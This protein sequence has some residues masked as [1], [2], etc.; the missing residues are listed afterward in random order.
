MPEGSINTA[1]A[2]YKEVI[3]MDDRTKR[4][5]KGTLYV[6]QRQQEQSEQVEEVEEIEE[7]EESHGLLYYLRMVGISIIVLFGILVTLF[8]GFIFLG[9][10]GI[11]IFLVALF[12]GFLFLLG[13][14]RR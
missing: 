13:F 4:D 8:F 5:D 2:I 1:C 14:F 9:I 6:D 12:F 7:I 10:I 11:I 3:R